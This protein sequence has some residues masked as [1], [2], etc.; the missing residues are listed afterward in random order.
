VKH[1]LKHHVFDVVSMCYIY[2]ICT[3]VHILGFASMH[4]FLKTCLTIY[5]YVYL[6]V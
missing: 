5:P 3:Y 6:G 1:Q 4:I 2:G